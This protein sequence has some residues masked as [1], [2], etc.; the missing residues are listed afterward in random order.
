[1][2]RTLY[3]L[4]VV[5][6]LTC[7]TLVQA[8]KEFG[9]QKVPIEIGEGV[10]TIT[11]PLVINDGWL[12][13]Q[14][15]ASKEKPTNKYGEVAVYSIQVFYPREWGTVSVQHH[16]AADGKWTGLY[17]LTLEQG[18]EVPWKFSFVLNLKNPLSNFELDSDRDKKAKD[19][20]V[21]ELVKVF[22]K[23]AK[24]LTLSPS[25]GMVEWRPV[26]SEKIREIT[27]EPHP[28]EWLVSVE[29]VELPPA[30]NGLPPFSVEKSSPELEMN[31]GKIKNLA[32]LKEVTPFLGSL[33]DFQR[34]RIKEGFLVKD[35]QNWILERNKTGIQVISTLNY[36]VAVS[37]EAHPTGH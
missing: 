13:V 32:S 21:V 24:N 19:D 29:R 17:T 26:D 5:A 15:V 9:N 20:Y 36:H 27:G 8:E 34:L 28:L 1:M 4:A 18:G 35:D 14:A 7:A 25:F 2:K 11:I 33:K 22:G 30:A 6:S 16:L 23:D 37:L 31:I 10:N 12:I 3:T